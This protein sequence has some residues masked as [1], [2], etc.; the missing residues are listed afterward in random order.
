MTGRG[1]GVRGEKNSNESRLN[2]DQEHRSSIFF[3]LGVL[4]ALGGER[5]SED[6]LESDGVEGS[7]SSAAVQL[8]E[9]QTRLSDLGGACRIRQQG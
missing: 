4:R 9:S 6:Q 8:H 5:V 7:L 3:F 1:C 2:S